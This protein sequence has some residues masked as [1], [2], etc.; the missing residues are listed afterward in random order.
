MY[1]ETHGGSYPS[2]HV[3][4]NL[5][6]ELVVW[7][8]GGEWI[9]C[10]ALSNILSVSSVSCFAEYLIGFLSF[11]NSIRQEHECNIYSGLTVY[12]I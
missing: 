10:E 6:N 4:L 5:L 8:G 2:A 11:I 7:V 9:R 1:A 3:V 12:R